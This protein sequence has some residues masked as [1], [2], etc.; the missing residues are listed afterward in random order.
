MRSEAQLMG[1][2]GGGGGR[3]EGGV[4]RLTGKCG[5]VEV[6]LQS[7]LHRSRQLTM[8]FGVLLYVLQP[9]APL[10]SGR[11]PTRSG[12]GGWGLWRGWG[13]VEAHSRCR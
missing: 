10:R 12:L 7:A 9:D 5:V 3:G 6:H 1:W 4:C 8:S 2:V 13:R 11:S